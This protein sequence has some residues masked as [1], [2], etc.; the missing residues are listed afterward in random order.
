MNIFNICKQPG[1]NNDLQ[2]STQDKRKFLN[3]VKNFYWDDPYLFKYCPDQIF[4]RCIPDNE[5]SSDTH[6]FC[7]ICEN[8]QKLGSI[9]KCHMMPLNPILSLKYLIVEV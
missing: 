1:D 8:Y 6:A 3:E 7:K 2:E 4:Q 5:V 9:S